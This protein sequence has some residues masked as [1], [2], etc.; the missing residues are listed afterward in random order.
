M[1]AY[2]RSRITWM[3]PKG[4][5]NSVRE[6]ESLPVDVPISHKTSVMINDAKVHL[7]VIQKEADEFLPLDIV[8]EV[9]N[10]S[11]WQ[12]VAVPYLFFVAV[13]EVLK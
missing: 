11:K 9:Q 8:Y 3:T 7:R 5:V 1:V 10:G 13:Q 2:V 4:E 6:R 12:K